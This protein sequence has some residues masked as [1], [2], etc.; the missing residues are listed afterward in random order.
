MNLSKLSKP[1]LS[2]VLTIGAILLNATSSFA[3][4]SLQDSLNMM[5]ASE[6]AV[7]LLGFA[8]IVFFLIFLVLALVFYTV[9]V[10]KKHSNQ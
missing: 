10:T 2:F 5:S 7:T 6:W 8:I 4:S 1:L 9:V 3:E